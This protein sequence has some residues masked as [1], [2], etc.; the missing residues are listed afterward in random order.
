[1]TRFS[2]DWSSDVCSS[3]LVSRTSQGYEQAIRSMGGPLRCVAP[4]KGGGDDEGTNIRARIL[5]ERGSGMSSGGESRKPCCM[6]AAR[7]VEIGRASCRERV[8]VRGAE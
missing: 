2:R 4:G 3:D 1:H 6:P 8:Q 7:S 5:G